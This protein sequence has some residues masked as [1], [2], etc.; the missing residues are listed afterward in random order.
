[1]LHL[2]FDQ[3]D[4]AVDKI[5]MNKIKNNVDFTVKLNDQNRL[6][7]DIID[8]VDLIETKKSQQAF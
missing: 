8:Y 7:T 2:E 1:M 3:D 4:G 6:E 5:E